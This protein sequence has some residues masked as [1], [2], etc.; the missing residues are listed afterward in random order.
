MNKSLLITLTACLPLALGFAAAQRS[1]APVGVSVS[2]AAPS[3]LPANVSTRQ[4]GP[5]LPGEPQLIPNT[6]PDVAGCVWYY[7]YGWR[8][9]CE[10][11]LG[12]VNSD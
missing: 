7:Y 2:N 6:P 3:R 10:A 4:L 1:P 11:P 9:A 12:P 8:L 5:Q